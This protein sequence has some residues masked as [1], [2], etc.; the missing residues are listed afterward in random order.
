MGTV[1]L[2]WKYCCVLQVEGLSSLE[3]MYR[4]LTEYSS[5]Y[6]PDQT[7]SDPEPNNQRTFIFFVSPI[8]PPPTAM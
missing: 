5:T 1:S 7:K 3:D 6:Y 8:S 4:Y 2:K